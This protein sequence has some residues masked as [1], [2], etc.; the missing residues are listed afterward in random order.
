V[1]VDVSGFTLF[2]SKKIAVREAALCG[3]APIVRVRAFSVFGS[4]KVWSP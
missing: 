3:S 2:G 4:V 1:K